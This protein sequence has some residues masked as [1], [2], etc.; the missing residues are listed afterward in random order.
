MKSGS[1]S[2]KSSRTKRWTKHWFVLKNDVLSWY[3]SAAVSPC[4]FDR[5][6]ALMIH[7]K[8]PYFPH[9]N[10]DLRYAITCESVGE[11]EIK[12]RTNQ[13]TLNLQADSIPS[14]D[15]WVKAVR[16][17]MFK[18][19]NHGESVK[20]SLPYSAIIDVEKSTAM[21][22]SDTIEVKVVD[23]DDN[24][25]IDSY[26]FAYFHNLPA[27]LV[28]IRECVQAY[29]S[30]LDTDMSIVPSS[31]VR[32]T[33][34]AA[35]A[36]VLPPALTT[37]STTST[38]TSQ[39]VQS[40]QSL[41]PPQASQGS[42]SRF[43]LHITS[44]LG[45]NRTASAPNPSEVD[46]IGEDFTHVT[47]A[48]AVGGTNLPQQP[49]DVASTPRAGS[50]RTLQPTGTDHTYPPSSSLEDS[51]NF[52]RVHMTDA[53]GHTV[54][55][56]GSALSGYVPSWLKSKKIFGSSDVSP[57]EYDDSARVQEIYEARPGAGPIGGSHASSTL[58]GATD[59]QLGFSIL[60]APANSDTLDPQI[61]DKFKG[62]FALDEKEQV[63][64][65]T[66]VGHYT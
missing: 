39:A 3:S 14:R 13:K 40:V 50:V 16:K 48:P 18:A 58:S 2:K 59:N 8:D 27:A 5:G 46:R 9:G 24:F 25:A 20:I 6:I 51:Q 17:V 38:N 28:Q 64:G 22:F 37:T 23:K 30:A 63:L 49:S 47:Y 41:P 19:Q 33:T 11:R 45:L 32:D 1:L 65:C 12:L 62:Y 34:T 36:T 44:L 52:E 35:R 53:Q 54:Q 43:S 60:E 66:Y 57:V 4:L 42:S 10:V 7:F 55:P 31:T 56:S 21:D 15:E 29:K 26:F 61:V